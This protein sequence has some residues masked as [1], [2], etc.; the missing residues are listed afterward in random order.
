MPL[1]V[2][3]GTMEGM[4]LLSTARAAKLAVRNGSLLGLG[5]LA[6]GGL[7]GCAP[8]GTTGLPST[9]GG[10]GTTAQFGGLRAAFSEAGVAWASAGR[11][12]VARAPSFR[13]VCP[14][15]PPVV[16]VAWNGG[17]AWAGVPSLGAVVTLDGA[18]RSVDVGRVAALSARRVYR[19]NGSAVDYLGAAAAGTL[20]FP[21][22][23][24][25]GG[26][27]QEYLLVSGQLIRPGGAALPG[28]GFTLLNWRPD[29]AEGGL[30][31]QVT[32]ETGTY[33]LTGTELQRLDAAGIVRAQVP[34]GPGRLG[35]VGNWLVT[36]SPAGEVRV[37]LP[38]LS[39]R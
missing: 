27:G 5:L 25:T 2:H 11:A 24:L 3:A 20:G 32:T 7:S 10:P 33:R 38:D 37:F 31:P 36:V 12:C 17:V 22:A 15:L 4:R 8:A 28:W 29:G 39:A 9:K 35:A 21:E 18:P 23:A 14:A 16:D 26:D 1:R 34:H 30:Q 6:L 13:P 19:E